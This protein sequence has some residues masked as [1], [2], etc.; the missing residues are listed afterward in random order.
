MEGRDG[1][2][3]R[4]DLK[5]CPLRGCGKKR[6]P[7]PLIAMAA[8]KGQHRTVLLALPMMRECLVR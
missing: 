1:R 3:E 5:F 8:A 6:K 7:R 2:R 4:I